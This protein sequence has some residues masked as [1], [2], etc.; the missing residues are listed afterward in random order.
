MPSDE[1][2]SDENKSDGHFVKFAAGSGM[3]QMA[4]IWLEGSVWSEAIFKAR[5][6]GGVG[7]SYG[8]TYDHIEQL[9]LG[10]KSPYKS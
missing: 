6:S 10:K 5:V 9:T 4:A 7:D 1:D 3:L 2:K 8:T